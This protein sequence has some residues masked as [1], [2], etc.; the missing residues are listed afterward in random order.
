MTKIHMTT[1]YRLSFP[2]DIGCFF[3]LFSPY[4]YLTI[5]I[6]IILVFL[7][8]ENYYQRPIN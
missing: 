5:F 8:Q 7:C 4:L 1:S 2:F 6:L 3:T